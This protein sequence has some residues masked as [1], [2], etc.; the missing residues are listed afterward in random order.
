MWYYVN[1]NYMSKSE[2]LLKKLREN[3]TNV[4]FEV[5]DKVLQSYG[6]ECRQPRSGSSHYIY[7]LKTVRKTHIITVPFR[8]PLKK[9]Y[10]KNALQILDEI[11]AEKS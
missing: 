9:V 8:K 6:F 3:P 5:L 7:K 10:V 1:G 4:R 11:D 2:K